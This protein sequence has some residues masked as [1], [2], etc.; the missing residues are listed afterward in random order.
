MYYLLLLKIQDDF[1][2]NVIALLFNPIPRR[3]GGGVKVTF[4]VKFQALS[5]KMTKLEGG[6][7]L[8][9][10]PLCRISWLWGLRGIGLKNIL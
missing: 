2:L 7:T 3:G 1:V 5:S 9:P 6:V 10:P 8:T 4:K